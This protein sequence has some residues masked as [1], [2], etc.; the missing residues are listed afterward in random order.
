MSHNIE[1]MAYANAAPWHRL[2]TLVEDNISPEDLR[3]KAGLDWTISK[4]SLITAVSKQSVPET[5][6]LVRSSDESVLGTCGKQYKPVQPAEVLD[7]FCEFVEKGGMKMETA[8]SL[9]N[10][11]HIWAL[12]AIQ[13]G[14]TLGK[15]DRTEGYLLFSSPNI[16]GKAL[17]IMF[18]PVRVVCNNT[19][20]QALT[21][22][23]GTGE[24]RL[25][26]A[27]KFDP[28]IAKA[29]LFLS[30]GQLEEFHKVAEFLT[31]KEVKEDT[32]RKYFMDVWPT[33]AQRAAVEMHDAANGMTRT[34]EAAMD[35]FTHQPGADLFPNTWWNAFNTV[36]Y[37]IDHVAGR[38]DNNRLRNAWFGG[39]EK[40]KRH[41]LELAVNNAREAA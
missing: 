40:T 24:F 32:L 18:T 27:N 21:N 36:T 3:I 34:A 11:K 15:Q 6:A 16:V 38:N 33:A 35:I 26:H 41:A 23:S 13:E 17:R 4:E 37:I 9:S 1:T 14:F 28:D 19:L 8:G 29:T 31:T 12:A 7:F 5:Y 20:T 30:K 25:H 39:G 10:G 22:A 2:G